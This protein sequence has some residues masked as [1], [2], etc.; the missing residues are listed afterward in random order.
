MT[1]I[2]SRALMEN[3]ESLHCSPGQAA[4]FSRE[5]GSNGGQYAPLNVMPTPQRFWRNDK[6]KELSILSQF[7]VTWK[8]L[9][10]SRGADVLK[11]FLAGFPVRTSAQR[12]MA[13][14]ST[15]KS[16]GCGVKWLGLSVKYCRRSSGWKTHHCLLN[17]DLKP[18]SVTLPKWGMMRNGELWARI[19]PGL[20][21]NA[22]EYGFL[23]T[24]SATDTA[25]RIP[26]GEFK[27]TKSGIP[28]HLDKNGKESQV[29]LSQAVKMLFPTPTAND[30]RK[31]MDFNPDTCKAGIAP[32]V[33][34]L[35]TPT[36]SMNTYQDLIQAGFSFKNRPEYGRIP[37]PK[38]RDWKTGDNPESRRM[39]EKAKGKRHSPDLNDVAAPCGALNPDWVEWVMGWPV[40]WTRVNMHP[41]GFKNWDRHFKSF[42][43]NDLNLSP[44]VEKGECEFR[45]DRL[46]AIGNGQVPAAF[47]LAWEILAGK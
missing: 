23:P 9:T 28:R 31:G 8:P 35:P 40:G 15:A 6:M 16:P 25:D 2:F 39:R 3:Y 43:K 17:E 26:P 10:E 37:T 32:Y 12:E 47:I 38:A 13:R 11:L 4:A 19:T 41:A 33:K 20:T 34:S 45:C 46:K 1:W 44:T 27:L 42:W 22:I 36:A 5:S 7:G 18:S 30:S 21:T 24:P 14:E 29:R